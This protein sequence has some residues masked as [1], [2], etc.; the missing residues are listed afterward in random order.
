MGK[1]IRAEPADI[2]VVLS[3]KIAA[4]KEFGTTEAVVMGGMQSHLNWALCNTGSK[5]C[6]DIVV[7]VL[8]S[9][10][11]LVGSNE[12]SNLSVKLIVKRELKYLLQ[13]RI[14]QLEK[15]ISGKTWFSGSFT[16]VYR[17]EESLK[18]ICF[19]I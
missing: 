8:I 16:V 7:D 17:S 3:G 11:E 1:I 6:K 5:L 2:V 4:N 19:S 10:E 15:F 9:P 12:Q 18:S 13:E 14:K